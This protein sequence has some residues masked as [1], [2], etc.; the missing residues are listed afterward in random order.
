MW[1]PANVQMNFT[2]PETRNIVLPE[3]ENRM[4]VFLFVW[5]K[6]LNVTERRTDRQTDRNAVA[7]T[8]RNALQAMRTRCNELAKSR[9]SKV[10]AI[11]TDRQTDRHKD[12]HTDR[13]YW[14]HYQAAFVGPRQVLDLR[15]KFWVMLNL[16]TLS[17]VNDVCVHCCWCD[18]VKITFWWSPLWC[19]P[20]GFATFVYRFIR[21]SAVYL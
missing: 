7:I 11:Q 18:T 19:R 4:I 6:H 10:R 14:K 8:A 9:L 3:S 13:C 1:S 17:V 16:K 21:S 2:S 12:R 20:Y 15:V 5:T